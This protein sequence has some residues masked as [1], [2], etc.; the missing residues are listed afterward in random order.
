MI[1]I[2]LLPLRAERKKEEAKYAVSVFC[3][4]VLLIVV[5]LGALHYRS[6][7]KVATLK[8]MVAEKEAKIAHY[9]ALSEEIKILKAQKAALDS[10][11]DFI[12]TL[13]MQKTGP[14][15][16]LDELASRLPMQRL[17]LTG[18]TQT[19]QTLELNGEALDNEAIADYMRQLD[20]SDYLT[21]VDLVSAEQASRNDIKIMKFS[22]ICKLSFD[23]KNTAPEA[24]QP[25]AGKAPEGTQ[26]IASA[27]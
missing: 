12:K 25:T 11:L 13:E 4:V 22:I 15:H 1:R 20:G 6:A 2:N 9:K 27:K 26:R 5:G 14:V 24:A 3:L 16:L 8:Q 19:P 21:S 17:W 23:K 10:K 18:L 7:R